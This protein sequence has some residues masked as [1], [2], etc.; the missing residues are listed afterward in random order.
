M[1]Q[2]FQT[3]EVMARKEMIQIGKGR[4]HPFAQGLI[5]STSQERV[6]PDQLFYLPFQ[7]SHLRIEQQIVPAIPA[8][9]EDKKDGSSGVEEVRMTLVELMKC[10]ADIR[11]S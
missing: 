7:F 8:I 5:V 4:R 3:Q 10:P 1:A 9:T 11:P 6:E 2:V